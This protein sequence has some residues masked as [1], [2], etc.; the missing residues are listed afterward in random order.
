MCGCFHPDTADS[1]IDTSDENT[2]LHC[3]CDGGVVQF[4]TGYKLKKDGDIYSCS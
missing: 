2:P 1:G 4:D 3:M